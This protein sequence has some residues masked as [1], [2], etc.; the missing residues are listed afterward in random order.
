MRRALRVVGWTLLSVVV[1]FLALCMAGEIR[2]RVLVHRAKALMVDIQSLQDHKSTWADAQRLMTKWGKW[3]RY[4]GSCTAVDCMYTVSLRPNRPETCEDYCA[5]RHLKLRLSYLRLMPLQWGSGLEYAGGMFLVQDGVVR[6]KGLIVNYLSASPRWLFHDFDP[7]N[8]P[9]ITLLLNVSERSALWGRDVDALQAARHPNLVVS[10][11]PCE[12]CEDVKA[13]LAAGSDGDF[14]AISSLR[15]DCVTG[16]RPCKSLD[17]L[18]LHPERWSHVNDFGWDAPG[19][20]SDGNDPSTSCHVSLELRARDERSMAVVEAVGDSE[21]AAFVDDEKAYRAVTPVRVIEVLQGGSDSQ[22]GHTI[23]LSTL[24]RGN[25]QH[26]GLP[27]TMRKGDRAVILLTNWRNAGGA[28]WW[29]DLQ[30]CQIV[31]WSSGA[32]SLIDKGVTLR[33]PIRG[34]EPVPMFQS[35]L[36]STAWTDHF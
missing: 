29:G 36:R 34:P 13:T 30:P 1:V 17:Q 20:P 31:P 32:M 23:R 12:G 22:V 21:K 26:P 11:N 33:D 2:Q 3:G 4:E 14:A 18:V 24:G 35:F 8:N 9:M 28:D 6:R 15:F 5:W 19:D 10:W 25:L 7:E 27:A 16:W